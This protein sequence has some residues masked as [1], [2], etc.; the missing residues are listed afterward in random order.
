MYELAVIESRPLGMGRSVK[1]FGCRP[2]DGGCGGDWGPV[3]ANLERRKLREVWRC[4]A[5]DAM[6]ISMLAVCCRR[7]LD[8]C[9]EGDR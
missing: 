7:K 8:A 4:G 3:G 2:H 6:G 1:V 9:L 5:S